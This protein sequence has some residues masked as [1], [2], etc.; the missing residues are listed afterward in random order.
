MR[1]WWRRPLERR[2]LF[3]YLQIHVSYFRVTVANSF[4]ML[5]CLSYQGYG[6]KNITLYD[7][8]A[9]LNHR[10]KDMRTIYRQPTAE[11]I[12]NMLTGETPETFYIG[13]LVM[14]KVTG[15]ARRKPQNG[16][17]DQVGWRWKRR[18]RRRMVDGFLAFGCCCC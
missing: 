6:N 16:D 17:T 4:S 5:P 3:P 10:Y 9:E 1:W 15:I 8:R 13:K 2:L 11:E 12:F 7:I 14:V 18:R